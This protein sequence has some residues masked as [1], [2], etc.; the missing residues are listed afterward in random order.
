MERREGLIDLV[1]RTIKN[2]VP[3]C[4]GVTLG[5][6]TAYGINDDKS[7]VEMYFY[8]YDKKPD[9]DILTIALLKIGAKHKRSDAFLWDE[10]PWGPHSFFL[11]EDIYFEV[12]YRNVDDIRSK[13]KYYMDGNVMPHQDFRDLG[14]GYLYGS[15]VAS[16]CAEKCLYECAE[17]YE[18]KKL[19]IAFPD[20]L[21]LS[22]KEE[23]LDTA[24]AF[25]NGK[26]LAA[27]E[28]Q[29]VL[30]YEIIASR[31]IRSL[32]IMAFAKS[33]KHF[34]GDK[35]NERLLRKTEWIHKEQFIKLINGH[36][37]SCANSK[38]EMMKRRAYLVEAMELLEL[39]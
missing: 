29:D 16:V 20:S 3:N 11:I 27:V 28:R 14:L 32:Y 39:M 2:I 15:L 24:K 19:A 34:P 25:L 5:G 37:M 4:C 33:K 26:L 18:L 8:T 21:Y 1:A 38:D 9:L 36:I 10:Q 12:G 31:I 7:D 17:I 6:S 30:F 13:I 35:W 23:Y 22:L